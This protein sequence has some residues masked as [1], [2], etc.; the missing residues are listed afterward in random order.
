MV[1]LRFE[2]KVLVFFGT[3]IIHGLSLL[4][5]CQCYRKIQ[6]FTR[7]FL[8]SLDRSELKF[9]WQVIIYFDRL[10][11]RHDRAKICLACQHSKLFL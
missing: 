6:V 8:L 9:V 4:I 1:F 7:E 5:V 10:V 3:V 11:I 2:M